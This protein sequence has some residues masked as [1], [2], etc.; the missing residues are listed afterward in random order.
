MQGLT[1][2]LTNNPIKKQAKD[3]S[4]SMF[5]QRRQT[6]GSFAHEQDAP[7]QQSLEMHLAALRDAPHTPGPHTHRAT[8][9]DGCDREATR[10][11]A[12]GGGGRGE[13]RASSAAH[14]GFGGCSGRT[15]SFQ[16]TRRSHPW[17]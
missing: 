1:G 2:K 9:Y 17:V 10:P 5:L 8:C 15:Q 3:L 7:N 16:T 6:N 4:E 14:R 12:G 13:A 11:G